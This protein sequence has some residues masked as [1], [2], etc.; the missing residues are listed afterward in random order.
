[1]GILEMIS[2]AGFEEFFRGVRFPSA[3]IQESVARPRTSIG[4]AY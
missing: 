1:V 4:G 3:P 2:P